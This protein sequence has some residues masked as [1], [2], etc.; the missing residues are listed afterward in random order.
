MK[1]RVSK[2]M[3]LVE[4]LI[5]ALVFSVALAALLGCLAAIIDL[6]DIARDATVATSDLS[7]VAER[8]RATGF[9]SITTNFPDGD[10]DGP[11]SNPYQNIT[12]GYTLNNEQITV[13]YTNSSAD[14]LE[15]CIAGTWRDKK[16]H[17][18][19]ANLTTSRTR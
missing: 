17:S 7:T 13:T 14:P 15:I 8:I 9:D 2:G 16:N 5:A 4:I 19:R 3:T 12:G 11:A 6:I 18:Y 1:L 10:V